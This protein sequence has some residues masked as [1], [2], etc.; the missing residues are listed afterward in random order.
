MEDKSSQLHEQYSK[1]IGNK[2]DAA[3]EKELRSK[4]EELTIRTI[5]FAQNLQERQA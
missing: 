5:Y 2:I 1:E 4:I 3:I